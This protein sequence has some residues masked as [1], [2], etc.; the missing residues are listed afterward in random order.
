[1]AFVS[2]AGVRENEVNEEMEELVVGEDGTLMTFRALIRKGRT[3][4][5]PQP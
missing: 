5:K 2:V 4:K 1:M 3:H